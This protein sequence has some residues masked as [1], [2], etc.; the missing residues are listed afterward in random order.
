MRRY[1]GDRPYPDLKGKVVVIVDD[2][3]ATGSTMRAAIRS[4]KKKSAKTVVVAAPVGSRDS[5][6]E[7]S[8]EADRLV[9][10]ETPEPFYAISQFYREFE[11]VD[12]DEVRAELD[13]HETRGRNV[14]TPS[15]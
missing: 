2:G 10:L 7:L 11:Q 1:R 12:D 13:R 15:Q 14:G 5:V 9:C 6:S 3:I 8:R 4:V